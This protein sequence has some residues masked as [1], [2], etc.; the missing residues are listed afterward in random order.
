LSCDWDID[1]PAA[2]KCI[3]VGLDRLGILNGREQQV[4]QPLSIGLTDSECIAKHSRFVSSARMR[5]T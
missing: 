2:A 5:W 1:A 4:T 3:H